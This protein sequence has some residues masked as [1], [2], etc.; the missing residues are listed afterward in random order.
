[1]V[2]VASASGFVTGQPA[3]VFDTSGTNWQCSNVTAVNAAGNTVTLAVVQQP[4]FAGSIIAQGGMTGMGFRMNI[5]CV[6]PNNMQGMTTVDGGPVNNI[7][8]TYPIMYNTAGSV[9]AVVTGFK[10]GFATRGYAAMGSGG[11]VTAAVSGGQ[12]TSCSGSG[13]SGYGSWMGPQLT[14]T[15]N[16]GGTPPTT[17]DYKHGKRRLAECM[18]GG[19]SR[20]ESHVGER[21]RDS[22]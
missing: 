11:T 21:E 13:G 8:P 10:V 2:S 1:M 15:V 20:R 14:Y 16:S 22:L 9:A 6:G 4:Q 12:V 17:G 3:C 18:H 7:C 5:D 19:E